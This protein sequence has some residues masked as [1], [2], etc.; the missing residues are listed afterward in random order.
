MSERQ[1][2]RRTNSANCSQ[3]MMVEEIGILIVTRISV[4]MRSQKMSLPHSREREANDQ[5]VAP[6][7]LRDKA[8]PLK[9]SSRILLLC[10]I[11]T[12]ESKHVATPVSKRIVRTDMRYESTVHFIE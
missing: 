12:K 4:V 9:K 10:P 11:S 3:K 6:E 5:T 1:F 7:S 8:V 2:E